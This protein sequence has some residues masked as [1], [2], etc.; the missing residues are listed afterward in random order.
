MKDRY[1]LPILTTSL[2]HFSLKSWENVFFDFS[3]HPPA[4]MTETWWHLTTSVWVFYRDSI[5]G[6]ISEV[7][8]VDS[9]SGSW[10]VMVVG[11]WHILRQVNELQRSM[12]SFSN[13]VWW[14]SMLRTW[15]ASFL[16]D[17][18]C[19]FIPL[20]E[21]VHFSDAISISLQRVEVGLQTN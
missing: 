18:L 20:S 19:L 5:R 15:G 11:I 13:C 17:Q 12:F 10:L 16:L 6:K 14:K 7:G 21:P 3:S 1:T 2:I 4:E 8:Q 9:R